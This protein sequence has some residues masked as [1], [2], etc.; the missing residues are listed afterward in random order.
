MVNC[1]QLWSI[2][3]LS[4]GVAPA[5]G[6]QAVRPFQEQLAHT[7]QRP[8]WAKRIH[9]PDT[10]DLPHPKAVYG[11]GRPVV[12]TPIVVASPYC[13]CFSP[14]LVLLPTAGASP[15]RL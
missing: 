2:S 10:E 4:I 12:T 7:L 1:S 8:G 13:R 9:P 6:Q 5:P 14:L 3:A 11:G 15:K